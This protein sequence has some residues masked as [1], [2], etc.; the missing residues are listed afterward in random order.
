MLMIGSSVRWSPIRATPSGP[1]TS[2]LVSW[3]AAKTRRAKTYAP[4]LLPI[5][6]PLAPVA[7]RAVLGH[8]G[9]M[10]PAAAAFM[11]RRLGDG[12]RFARADGRTDKQFGEESGVCVARH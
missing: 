5:H 9:Q 7:Q 4:R 10:A 8:L 12:K 2:H 3:S 11:V 1:V 6:N